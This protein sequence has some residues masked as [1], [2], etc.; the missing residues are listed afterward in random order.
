MVT[1]KELQKITHTNTHTH[2]HT[3]T[4]REREFVCL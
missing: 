1:F 2:T 3:D 4:E